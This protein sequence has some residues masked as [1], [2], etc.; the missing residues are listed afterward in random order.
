MSELFII[1]FII[2]SALFLLSFILKLFDKDG[3]WAFLFA[4]FILFGV[5]V[6]RLG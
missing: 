1:K 2:P 4:G 6:E 5:G 3:W